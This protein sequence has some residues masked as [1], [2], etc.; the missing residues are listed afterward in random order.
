MS[1]RGRIQVVLGLGFGDEGKGTIVDWL[2]RA[3]PT[4]PLVI[5]WNGGPQAMHHVVTDDGRSHCFAQLG[6]AGFVPG[7]RTHLGPDMVVDPYALH[8]EAAA[9]AAVGVTGALSSLSIDP[10]CV[11]VTPWHAI[12]NRV[13]ELLRGDARHGSTGRGIAEAR[14]GRYQLRAGQLGPGFADDARFLQRA[15]AAEVE[16]LLAAHPRASAAARSLAAR[17]EDD[18]LGHAFVEAGRSLA[19]TGVA[20]TAAVPPAEDV[21][22]ESAQG[23][24][25]DQDHG[26]FPHVT[27]SRITRTAAEDAMRSLGL[28]GSAEIWGVLRA[29][30]TRHG[31]GPLPSDDPALAARLAELHNPSDG[32]SG[33]FRVG[34]FDAVLARHALG[35]AGPIDR[36]ALTC[37]DRLAAL[38]EVAVVDAW[39]TPTAVI[40]DLAAIPA[41]DRTRVAMTARPIIRVVPSIVA[42]IEAALGRRVDVTSWGPTA[43][44]KRS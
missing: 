13:R 32:W 35:C 12:V 8:R 18:D 20:I 44:G 36:L 38:D 39:Q 15:L 29:Y 24:L 4:P 43:S 3:A 30:Q 19:A 22:L 42:A 21:I 6:A 10:R 7:A 5:R 33:R 37:V 40:T 2:A 17:A 9:L 26:F 27:P 28:V 25:L 14:R 31:E 34:W 16:A 1:P 11:L 23:A 41:E